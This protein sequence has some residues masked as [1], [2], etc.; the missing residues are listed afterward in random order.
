ERRHPIRHGTNGRQIERRIAG[1]AGRHDPSRQRRKATVSPFNA[2]STALR[3]KISQNLFGCAA[4]RNKGTCD[5]RLNIRIDALEAEILD[6]LRHRLMAPDLFKEFCQEFHREVN[7]LRNTEC[8]VAESQK[9]ELAQV[10]RRIRKLV[11]LITDDDAPV[12]A[13]KSEL[14][15]LERR[16]GELQQSLAGRAAPAPLIHP[17]LAEIYRQRVVALQDALHEPSSRDEAFDA[18]RS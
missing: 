2:R 12:Q 10:E 1:L 14:K 9:A 7:R 13:L 18:I 3:V 11:E 8:A 4:A 5:N 15:S 6:G 17:N 16:Q